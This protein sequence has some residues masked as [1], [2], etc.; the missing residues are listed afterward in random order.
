MTI[1]N[2]F[3]E[4]QVLMY[5][6]DIISCTINNCLYL[7]MHNSIRYNVH[8]NKTLEN[9]KFQSKYEI[10]RVNAIYGRQNS[11]GRVKKMSS[12]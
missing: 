10:I 4:C 8:W 2:R 6:T 9:S 1:L 11:Y 3:E 5:L 12:N 7:V